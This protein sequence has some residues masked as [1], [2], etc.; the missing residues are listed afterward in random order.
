MTAP[1][2]IGVLGAARITQDA[3]IAPAATVE[4]VEVAAI[5]ARDRARAEEAAQR[6]GIGTVH[7]SYEALLGD[8]GIQAIYNPL[9]ASLHGRWTRAALDAGKHVLVEKPFTANADEAREV[10]AAA[11]ASGLVVMEAHH[12]SHHPQTRRAAELVASGVLGELESAEASFIVP[13]P[14]GGD[15]RWNLALGGG[16][17]MDLGCYPLRWLRDVLGVAPTVVSATASDRDGIDAA[18]DARLDYAG[19]P[20][21]VRAAMWSGKGVS[22]GIELRGS[23][24]VMKVRSPYAPQNRGRIKVDGP[25][26]LRI[27]EHADPRSSYSFQLEAFRDAALSGGP[28]IT[29]AAAAVETM[30]AIDAI[31]RAA[32]MSPRPVAV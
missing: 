18:M 26:G 8:P 2:R 31:Y 20:G 16:S 29:D 30:T 17:L 25:E 28:N 27:R 12:S 24:G 3:L 14:P 7:E 15:I 4:G 23:A 6:H 32:G 21:R 11:E 22:I 19:T 5:A 10:Q 1:L 9:P 13:I